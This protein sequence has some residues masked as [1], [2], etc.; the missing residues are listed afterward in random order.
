MVSDMV[1]EEG[2]EVY[3]NFDDYKSRAKAIMKTLI[4]QLPGWLRAVRL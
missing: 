2:G 4:E 3:D 1:T